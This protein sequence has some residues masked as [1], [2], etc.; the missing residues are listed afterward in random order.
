MFSFEFT[1]FNLLKIHGVRVFWK[2]I[3]SSP[4]D[5]QEASLI[6]YE[7]NWV[8]A[9]FNNT[10]MWLLGTAGITFCPMFQTASVPTCVYSLFLIGSELSDSNT[11][12][13]LKKWA[14]KWRRNKEFNIKQS[15]GFFLSNSLFCKAVVKAGTAPHPFWREGTR[16]WAELCYT[17][18]S[19]SSWEALEN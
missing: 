18:A 7:G 1:W 15:W 17:A 11:V 13:S 12:P 3:C 9:D 2:L 19:Q 5:W 6:C 8:F 10:F 16:G 14:W 4:V